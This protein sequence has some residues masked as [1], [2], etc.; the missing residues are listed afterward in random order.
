MPKSTIQIENPIAV[1][2]TSTNKT[3]A[4]AFVNYLRTKPAQVIFAQNGYRPVL[5]SAAKG[6]S[7]PCPPERVLDPVA[8]RLGEGRQAVLRL[9][10]RDRDEDPAAARGLS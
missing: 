3:T 9:A 2:K 1:V 6:F 4:H 5:R 8:R 10:Q 7:F